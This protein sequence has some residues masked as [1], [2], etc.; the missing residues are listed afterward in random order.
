MTQ[1]KPPK[2]INAIELGGLLHD[3]GK[4]LPRPDPG[5]GYLHR[6]A[7]IKCGR[8]LWDAMTSDRPYRKAL[9]RE[10]ALEQL[11]INRGTQFDPAVVDAFL[12]LQQEKAPLPNTKYHN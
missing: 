10:K 2:E 7:Y 6:S 3:V 9:T 5:P 12:H 11:V 8:C 4:V 1:N